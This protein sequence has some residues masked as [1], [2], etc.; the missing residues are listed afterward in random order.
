MQNYIIRCLTKEW[1]KNGGY[2]ID[3][4]NHTN[5]TKLKLYLIFESTLN[6]EVIAKAYNKYRLEIGRAK[7]TIHGGSSETGYFLVFI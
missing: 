6:I 3:N 2:S 1:L 7:T 4:H 5:N